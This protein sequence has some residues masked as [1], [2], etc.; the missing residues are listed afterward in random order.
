ML[1]L[2]V[3]VAI[4]IWGTFIKGVIMLIAKTPRKFTELLL[5]LLPLEQ[6]EAVIER[7]KRNGKDDQASTEENQRNRES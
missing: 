7:R 3:E 1:W 5:E 2:T 6:L 4:I